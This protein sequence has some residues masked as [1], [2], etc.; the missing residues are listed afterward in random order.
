MS[1]S[2]YLAQVGTP[3]VWPTSIRCPSG[4]AGS[5]G[6]PGCDLG[7]GEKLGPA[8][9]P[10][11]ID[12]VDV[13]HREVAEGAGVSG[14]GRGSSTTPR[15][16]I[17]RSPPTVLITQL[18]ASLMMV[19]SPSRTTLPPSTPLEKPPRAGQV[20]GHHDVGQHEPSAGGGDVSLAIGA[21]AAHPLIAPP[22]GH[23]PEPTTTGAGEVCSPTGPA[24]DEHRPVV[25]GHERFCLL[26]PTR[27]PCR[28]TQDD[29]LLVHG[30]SI[31]AATSGGPGR[32][33]TTKPPTMADHPLIAP[34]TEPTR[35][36]KDHPPGGQASTNPPTPAPAGNDGHPP[37]RPGPRL[38]PQRARARG[39]CLLRSARRGSCPTWTRP[40]SRAGQSG[41]RTTQSLTLAKQGEHCNALTCAFEPEV[42]FEPTTFRSRVEEPSSSVCRPDPFWLLTSGGS[43][44]EFVPDL[45]CYGRGND[46]ENDQDASVASPLVLARDLTAGSA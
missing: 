34:G 23:R 13:G 22:G 27:L 29:H 2:R 21:R 7:W 25:A 16:V 45:P 12:A 1:S 14:I 4:C 28:R 26:G 24:G 5:S 36:V 3:V 9:A 20:R 31:P 30:Q 32:R 35:I 38:G 18:L 43:S 8:R 44:V 46:Q 42:G 39:G 33:P 6:S 10:L 19:G 40:A 15:V 41:R 37:T 11:L 17:G